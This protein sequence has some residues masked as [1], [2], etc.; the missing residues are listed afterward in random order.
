MTRYNYYFY[1]GQPLDDW[2]EVDEADNCLVCAAQ[3]L[4]DWRA[5]DR[6]RLEVWERDGAK[7][8]MLGAAEGVVAAL[9]ELDRRPHPAYLQAVGDELELEE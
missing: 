1:N 7:S 5:G 8:T 9:V 3:N 4:T 6:L 2:T